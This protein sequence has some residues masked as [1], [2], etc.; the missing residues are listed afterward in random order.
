M[1]LPSNTAL[2]MINEGFNNSEGWK[3]KFKIL[4]HLLAP[5]V[6]GK[7]KIAIKDKIT[8]LK[9]IIKHIITKFFIERFDVIK[10]IKSP[11]RQNIKCFL[12]IISDGKYILF[13]KCWEILEIAT[14]PKR[15]R[16]IVGRRI[17][18]S[19]FCHQLLFKYFSFSLILKNFFFY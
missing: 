11:K 17:Y 16:K 15:K 12:R 19:V 13:V 14:I 10:I 18:L 2:T 3:E 5:L 1:Y 6:S 9:K 4:I 8:A 7:K